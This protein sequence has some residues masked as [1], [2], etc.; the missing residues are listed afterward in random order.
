MIQ[1]TV[2]ITGCS[3]GIGRSLAVEY[4]R[5]G[6]LVVA[7]ARNT[8]T[9]QELARQGIII[10]ELDVTNTAQ[11]EQ[12]VDRILAKTGR[13]DVLVNN[14]GYGQ[15]GPMLDVSDQEIS[16]QFETN[17]FAPLRL[18][19]KV[20]HSMISQGRGRI[21]NIGSISGVVVTP[22]SGVYCGSKA[23]LHAFSDALRMELK[24]FG[25]QVFT[26]QPGAIRSNFGNSAE[27]SVQN[28]LTNQNSRYRTYRKAIKRRA[29]ASQMD[30]TNPDQLS[31]QLLDALSR[32]NPPPVIRLGKQSLALPLFKL[33]LP[34]SQLDRYLS[35]KFGL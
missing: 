18:I 27:Q 26:V 2:L 8:D 30:P 5:R 32:R 11:M 3:S 31:R 9:L 35:R 21:I 25:I 14:A 12:V 29:Q 24:P 7:S 19:R 10:E 1:E 13:I 4:A 16:R 6:F 15:M 33:L 20:V 34:L 28:Q 17:S 23:A 22:F